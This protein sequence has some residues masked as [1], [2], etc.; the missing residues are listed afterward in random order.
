MRNSFAAVRMATK[1]RVLPMCVLVILFIL[2]GT[3][4]AFAE[5][6]AGCKF[7]GSWI[8]YDAAGASWI[9]TLHGQSSSKGTY[10][11]DA[12]GFDT[13]FQFPLF[14]NAVMGVTFRGQ[15]TRTGD[16]TFVT[17]GI[18]IVVDSTNGS[19]LYIGKMSGNTTLS[20]ECN[21]MW[22]EDTAELFL[23]TQDPFEDDPFAVIT[24]VGHS[25]YR[26]SGEPLGIP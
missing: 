24:L 11:I 19:T 20:E 6:P 5:K 12:P 2:M 21:S 16:Y 17:T 7:Q 22:I 15:W 14:Q 8:G 1:K 4:T 13:T 18:A 23:P 10:V 26:I 9:G 3:A 25:G